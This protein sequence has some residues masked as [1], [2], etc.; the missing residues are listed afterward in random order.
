MTDTQVKR[1]SRG[2]GKKPALGMT[3]LRIDVEVLEHFRTH[4]KSNMQK[5]M[6]EVLTQ[7]VN[8]INKVNFDEEQQ[9]E[10]I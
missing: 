8:E 5:K 3:S 7:Y 10:N 9:N 6:R 4:H 2:K 1:R